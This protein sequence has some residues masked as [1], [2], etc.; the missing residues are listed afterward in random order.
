MKDHGFVSMNEIL[1]P[2]SGNKMVPNRFL[3][4]MVMENGILSKDPVRSA[5]RRHPDA[6][7]NLVCDRKLPRTSFLKL[8]RDRVKLVRI[9]ESV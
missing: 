4:T 2:S 7:S 3:R 9:G 5:E 8:V 6:A 1:L